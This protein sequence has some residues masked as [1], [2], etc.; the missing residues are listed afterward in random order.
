MTEPV[1]LYVEETCC[2][3]AGWTENGPPW[4][5][6]LGGGGMPAGYWREYRA[7]PAAEFDALAARLAE[8]ERERDEA[9]ALLRE[10]KPYHSPAPHSVSN[11]SPPE[12]PFGCASGCMACRI[13]AA[14]RGGEV[15]GA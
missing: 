3:R 5:S 10:C 6:T 9:R 8:A 2:R 4:R 15:A 1:R 11:V 14:L 7:L 13:E 12:P